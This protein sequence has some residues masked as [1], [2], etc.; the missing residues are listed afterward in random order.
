MRISIVGAYGY[1]GRLICAEFKNVG[2]AFSIFGRN[3]K[4]I[5]ELKEKF[6]LGHAKRGRCSNSY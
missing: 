6:G 2:I 4:K 5:L 3:E 1:T